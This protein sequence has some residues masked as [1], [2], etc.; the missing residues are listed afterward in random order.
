M[1]RKLLQFK[2][3]IFEKFECLNEKKCNG[4]CGESIFIYFAPEKGRHTKSL[5]LIYLYASCGRILSY[6]E[7]SN[8]ELISEYFLL[9]EEYF[10]SLLGNPTLENSSIN[11]R[12]FIIGIKKD[13]IEET[14]T[15]ILLEKLNEDLK[16][17]CNNNLNFSNIS[18]E[19]IGD[20]PPPL[21]DLSF[22]HQ[23]HFE[24]FPLKDTIFTEVRHT[25]NL[26]ISLNKSLAHYRDSRMIL[27]FNTVIAFYHGVDISSLRLF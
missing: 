6:K 9:L 14:Q 15:P 1:K 19:E 20:T 10:E 22:D 21:F 16:K 8:P 18:E 17:F 25:R 23:F 3:Q 4:C 27:V 13:S 11:L 2:F 26:M 7:T 12:K 24:F 5:T